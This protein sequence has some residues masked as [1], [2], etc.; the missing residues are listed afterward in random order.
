MQVSD[1]HNSGKKTDKGKTKSSLKDTIHSSEG[2]YQR[3]FE[4]VREG[5]LILDAETGQIVDVNPFLINLS[6]SSKEKLIEK[7]IWEI[8]F[9]KHIIPNEE[10]F[11]ELH[12]KE[13]IVY[14]DLPI[15]MADGRTIHIEFVTH[16]F[17]VN[18]NKIIQCHIRDIS[19]QKKTSSAL[20]G[21]EER[22]KAIWN[23][24][25]FLI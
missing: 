22:Y 2:C 20:L 10:K 24:F 14:E 3:L 1:N 7:R 13:H 25:I 4:S 11:L 21:N 9:F 23:L 15:Q 8:E 6:G 18:G 17:V 5:I 19:E 12:Q 16:Q